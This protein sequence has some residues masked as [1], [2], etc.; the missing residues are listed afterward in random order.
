[1]ALFNDD[2]APSQGG[3]FSTASGAPDLILRLKDGMDNAEPSINGVSAMNLNRLASILEDGSYAEAARK[4]VDAFE[5]EV[6]QHPFLFP[7]L[8]GS[9]VAGRLGVRSIQVVGAGKEA[10]EMVGSKA[11]WGGGRLTW[12]GDGRRGTWPWDTDTLAHTGAYVV[13]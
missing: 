7:T 6:M 13:G 12:R 10:E 3:F 5:A 2:T 8:L 1:M 11:V 4:T 9:V